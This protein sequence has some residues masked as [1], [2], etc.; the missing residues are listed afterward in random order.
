MSRVKAIVELGPHQGSPYAN[1]GVY[2]V[3]PD[4]FEDQGVWERD[5]QE[6][7]EILDDV[8]TGES[9]MGSFIDQLEDTLTLAFEHLNS[10]EIPTGETRAVR[11]DFVL[12]YDQAHRELRD[13]E[14]E[15]P[16]D[17]IDP[18]DFCMSI[19]VTTIEEDA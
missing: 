11:K 5:L 14:L 8:D 12:P 7:R 17:S 6:I 19:K 10:L 2:E 9:P 13:Q 15:V 4:A 16:K 3:G 18:Q 1:W